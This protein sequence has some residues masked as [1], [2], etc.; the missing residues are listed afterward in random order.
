MND[1]MKFPFW[2]TDWMNND[3]IDSQPDWFQNQN[4]Y[5]DAWSSFKQF[6]PSS[7]SGIPPMVEAM[8]SWWKSASPSLSG[9]NHDFYNKMMQQGQAFYFMGEQF[10]KILEGMNDVSKQ[11]EDWQNVLNDQFGSMKSML[12]GANANMQGAFTTSPF[13]TGGSYDEH[14]KV[15]EMTSFIEKL[16]SVPGF[17]PDRETQAQIQEGIK[18]L[19]DFQQVS[20]EYQAEMSKVGVEALEA[21]RLRILEMAEQGDEINSL[22]EIYNLWVDCNE[23][24][25][26]ELVYTDEYSE[27][28][29]RLTNALL[30][31]KQHQ[32]KVMDKLLAKLNIP[33][34]Q[35]MN[36]VLK[37]VQEMKRG[38]S[39]SAAKITALENELQAL[40]QLIEGEKKSSSP[41]TP[42][43]TST[44]KKAKKKT[45]KK[46]VAKKITKKTSKKTA[47]KSSANK[48]IVINI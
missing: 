13:M 14:F 3:W 20:S 19:N 8:N 35:V 7:S 31:V 26:A 17:G 28:Y 10:N 18:Q 33:T 1:K 32:G 40:R 11:S 29:G 22:R 48:T 21:M 37:R 15:A 5:M 41:A 4:Q 30:A 27:L 36:T 23:K 2:N 12:E 42:P 38:Q 47:R 46:K 24:A 9:Q 34:R 43:S 39:K 44:R 25:Y 16:L 6:M 45:A